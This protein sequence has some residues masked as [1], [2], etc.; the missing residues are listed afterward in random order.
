MGKTTR[1]TTEQFISEARLVHGDKY[2]YSL[3]EYKNNKTKIKIICPKHGLFE[4]YPNDH[5]NGHGCKKC[6]QYKFNNE[7]FFNK[8]NKIH[9]NKY[10]YFNDYTTSKN[11]IKIECPTHGI[12]YQLAQSHMNGAGCYKCEKNNRKYT[13]DKF[14]EKVNKI[15]NNKYRYFNDYIDIF[16]K[17]NIECPIHGIFKQRPSNHING[18]GCKKCSIMSQTYTL[19]EY[20]DKVNIVHNYMYDYSLLNYKKSH[21]YL[22]IICKKHGIFKQKAYLHLQGNGCPKCKMSKG[23]KYI[24]IYLND[25]NINF[26]TQKK[27]ENCKNINY[28]LFDFYLT[29]YNMCIE[30]DGKQHFINNKFFGGEKELNK[31]IINDNIKNEYCKNNNI[32]LLR[33]RYDENIEEKLNSYLKE[34]GII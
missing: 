17:I 19:E 20:I 16:T 28:L 31:R 4:Q 23:E 32:D 34:K 1:K 13:N 3:V 30:F 9:N 24:Y 7:I 5:L 27:F 2:D 18:Q 25:R 33:I 15:H 22:F 6:N 8:A 10:K 29:E 26:Q 21:N 11:K 12:F 14:I